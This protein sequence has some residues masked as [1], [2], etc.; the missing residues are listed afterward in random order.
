MPV[1]DEP[2]A[3]RPQ[4]R[5]RA[6]Y[7]ILPAIA[8]ALLTFAGLIYR[9]LTDAERI[10]ALAESYLEQYIQGRVV[11]GSASFSLLGG[12]QLSDVVVTGASR[13]LKPAARGGESGSQDDSSG[14]ENSGLSVMTCP[15][16]EI[17]HN[18]WA[19]L[20]GRLSIESLVAFEPTLS[21]VHGCETSSPGLAGLFRRPALPSDSKSR[22]L[23]NSVMRG[24]ASTS[25]TAG[26]SGWWRI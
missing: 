4:V 1:R 5:R 7:L 16:I 24:C 9:N 18:P 15:R 23:L 13:R 25:V 17:A 12:I 14:K 2:D 26:H 21:I 3:S 11:V 22:R 20:L 10:R 6:R 19:A 8:L